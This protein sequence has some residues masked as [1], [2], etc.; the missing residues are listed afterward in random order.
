MVLKNLLNSSVRAF[1]LFASIT[2]LNPAQAGNGGI[3]GEKDPEKRIVRS[4][5]KILKDDGIKKNLQDSPSNQILHQL[6]LLELEPETTLS[7]QCACKDWFDLIQQ[8]K[9]TLINKVNE[10]N[11]E[12]L[13]RISQ[14]F[15]R[16][17]LFHPETFLS[18][19]NRVASLDCDKYKDKPCAPYG[20][21]VPYYASRETIPD[22]IMNYMSVVHSA[23]K[24]H[25]F[26]SK[27]CV[28]KFYPCEDFKSIAL[29]DRILRNYNRGN[30]WTSLQKLFVEVSSPKKSEEFIKNS[31]NFE[32][33]RKYLTSPK[34]FQSIHERFMSIG[35]LVRSGN[36]IAQDWLNHNSRLLNKYFEFSIRDFDTILK[37][38][39]CANFINQPFWS[40]YVN[41]V[42]AVK[43]QLEIIRLIADTPFSLK[44]NPEKI[45][46]FWAYV[47]IQH[48]LMLNEY[49]DF[50]EDLLNTLPYPPSGKL[51]ALYKGVDYKNVYAVVE[52]VV[53]SYMDENKYDKAIQVLEHSQKNVRKS[54]FRFQ[55]LFKMAECILISQN[56]EKFAK[57]QECIDF[58]YAEFIKQKRDEIDTFY[59][60]QKM[61]EEAKSLK[62]C[63]LNILKMGMS[64]SKKNFVGLS[65]AHLACFEVG[66]IIYGELGKVILSALKPQLPDIDQVSKPI[67]KALSN[68][69]S[70]GFSLDT[71]K[72]QAGG[73]LM[74]HYG[75]VLEYLLKGY[76]K[77]HSKDKKEFTKLRNLWD[78]R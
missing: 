48:P 39:H 59:E 46:K 56:K 36:T 29:T 41:N 24:Y 65:P 25:P 67:R 5:T 28:R 27:M 34:N 50:I 75:D 49:S 72:T 62:E 7:L 74:I 64:L 44:L 57:A 52:Q 17:C 13:K 9:A 47:N 40:A 66:E 18:L 14:S 37:D 42:Q 69:A 2:T 1:V 77:N 58:I 78:R 76:F 33:F 73:N 51:K 71:F 61:D 11:A 23:K 15:V 30:E 68:E 20:T 60:T 4:K 45:E 43:S 26:F 53:K 10:F 55:I 12:E 22:G 16:Q 19:H 3:G 38:S 63:E 21:F 70:R 8:K 6:L 31:K 35:Y 54:S 32:S